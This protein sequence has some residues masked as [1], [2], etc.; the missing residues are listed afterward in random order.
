MPFESRTNTLAGRIGVDLLDFP[1]EAEAVV[2]HPPGVSELLDSP[3]RL[4]QFAV[5]DADEREIYQFL[6]SW[7]GEYVGPR[8]ICRRAGSKNRFRE[9]PEWAKPVLVRM[10]ER[11]ILESNATGH[12]RIK[13]VR[14]GKDN[15]DHSD[16]P[17]VAKTLEESGVEVESPGDEGSPGS[18]EYYDQL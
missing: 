10:E 12:F 11:G 18:D 6:K 3:A 9:D 15:Q 4:W 8:E 17:D 14:K 2:W 16:S 5:M 1:T 7:G 13:P